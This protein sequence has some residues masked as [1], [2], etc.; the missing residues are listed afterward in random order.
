MHIISGTE[1]KSPRSGAWPQV[2]NI[3]SPNASIF[4]R[5]ASMWSQK[6]SPFTLRVSHV[7]RYFD[8]SIL[9]TTLCMRYYFCFVLT[10]EKLRQNLS[11]IVWV[12]K[13]RLEHRQ[14]DTSVCLL[15]HY[16]NFVSFYP[17]SQGNIHEVKKNLHALQS[18]LGFND[19]HLLGYAL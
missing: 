10:M 6:Q 9:M 16:S 15:K 11:N 13:S 18:S 1:T 17:V 12:V 8:Y 7:P 19:R 2:P 5:L 4:S 14:A 3:F